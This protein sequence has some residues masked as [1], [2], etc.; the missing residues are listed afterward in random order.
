MT[1][2]NTTKATLFALALTLLFSTASAA[3][4]VKTFSEALE[5]AGSDGIVMF[6]YGPDWNRRSVRMLNEFWKT[7]GT[8]QACGNAA[9]VAVPFYQDPE[10]DKKNEA[11]DIAAGAPKPPFGVCPAVLLLDKEGKM[12]AHLVGTDYLGDFQGG[13]GKRNISDRMA[14]FRKRTELMEKAKNLTGQEKAKVIM[15]IAEL[16]I[17]R[18]EN[19]LAMAEEADPSDATG[20][21][22]RLKHDALQFMYGLLDTTDGFL[23]PDYVAD[24]KKIREE[25]QKV[26]DD[27]AILPVD[28]QKALAL[29]TGESRRQG[30]SGNK[31]TSITKYMSKIS[32]GTVFGRLAGAL[33]QKW[34]VAQKKTAE[35]KALERIAKRDEQ[36][37]Q[38]AKKLRERKAE[39]SI[40]ID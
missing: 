39:K 20:V 9:M 29:Q 13:L 18:P 19:L 25:T 37:A 12:Y 11:A 33:G 3:Q 38:S 15:E 31:L 40:Q 5:K 34:S 23:K 7:D 2:K 14:A 1:T 27:A 21:V 22:R 30:I 8:E 28:R 6:C 24:F 32:D 36:K 4:R 16:P 26:A 17:E 10:A 35:D